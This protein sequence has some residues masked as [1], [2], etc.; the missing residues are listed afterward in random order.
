[1]LLWIEDHKYPL[2]RGNIRTCGLCMDF[3]NT[4]TTDLVTKR[5]FAEKRDDNTT[6]L[7]WG[8]QYKWCKMVPRY[9]SKEKILLLPHLIII[10]SKI[11]CLNWMIIHGI[12]FQ[13]YAQFLGIFSKDSHWNIAIGKRSWEWSD[14]CLK[15]NHLF[16]GYP[17]RSSALASNA[18]QWWRL[19]ISPTPIPS[20]TMHL[21]G[22]ADADADADARCGYPLRLDRYRFWFL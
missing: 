15:C 6:F 2:I 5:Y 21:N 9:P 7:C 16:R 22:A 17:H 14:A 19:K 10:C 20:A 3:L 11:Y 8:V 1:M 12:Y 13:I 18:G 4:D